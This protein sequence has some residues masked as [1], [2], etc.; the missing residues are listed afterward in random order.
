[1]KLIEK[2]KNASESWAEPLGMTCLNIKMIMLKSAA[3]NAMSEEEVIYV[4]A[5]LIKMYESLT[6]S[7]D[8]PI[9]K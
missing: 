4:C 8:D 1:M 5:G 2:I 6:K 9:V 7:D 3:R